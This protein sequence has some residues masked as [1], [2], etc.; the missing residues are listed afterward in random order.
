MLRQA[1][2]PEWVREMIDHYRRTGSYRPED[3]ERLLGDP[4]KRVEVRAEVSLTSF[5]ADLQHRT[6]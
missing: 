4:N 5:L 2:P 6:S 3:L 1:P